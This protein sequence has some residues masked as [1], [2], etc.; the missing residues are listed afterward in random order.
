M[1]VTRHALQ[2]LY[3][4]PHVNNALAHVVLFC[5]FLSPRRLL[6][7][8]GNDSAPLPH[9]ND[10]WFPHVNDI[11]FGWFLIDFWNMC[12]QL[13]ECFGKRLTAEKGSNA[14]PNNRKNN[15]NSKHLLTKPLQ[16]KPASKQTSKQTSKQASKQTSKQ[17]NKRTNERTNKQ[18]NE[19]R[20]H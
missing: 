4:S 6:F 18:T 16:K 12:C 15:E 11:I 5:P 2:K 9:V 14:L 3:G 17:T 7:T 1:I 8:W 13:W 20:I 19:L 10:I